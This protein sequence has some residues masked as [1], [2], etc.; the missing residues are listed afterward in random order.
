[1]VVLAVA[2]LLLAG[3]G[4]P[5][6][7]AVVVNGTALSESALQSMT[8][9]VLTESA[10]TDS[11]TVPDISTI[12]AMNRQ[13][14]TNVIRHQLIGPAAAAAGV[15]VT[16]EQV[17][18]L[19]ANNSEQAIATQLGVPVSEVPSAVR[20]IGLLQAMLT[21]L[22]PAGT[23][24]T[25]VAVTADIVAATSRDDAAVKRARYAASPSAMAADM[26]AANVAPKPLTLLDN[27]SMAS[28]GVFAAPAGSVLVAAD[29]GTYSVI[30]VTTR[31]ELPGLLTA[32]KVS[33][34]ADFAAQVD[35]ASLL[36]ESTA[37]TAT[38]AV[39]PRF[40]VWDP[41]S[42]QVIPGNNGL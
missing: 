1:M 5:A 28:T 23:P 21:Q 17:N 10:G 7:D 27:A 18:A 31:A 15:T 26:V 22:P 14:A 38:I 9:T 36:L 13:Q 30:R 3:C 25:N 20:D 29:Q 2:A 19:I 40:G 24:V 35:I 11:T 33:E 39:N 37:K 34:G 4:T 32:A 12:S 6:G 42:I 16:D 41:T 8:S